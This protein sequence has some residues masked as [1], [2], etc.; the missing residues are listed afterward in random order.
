MHIFN[1][2]KMKKLVTLFICLSIAMVS[3][4]DKDTKKADDL[5]HGMAY[6]DAADAYLKLLKKGK[7]SRYVFEQLGNSYY[8]LNDLKKAETY[9]KRVAKGRR[10]NP[11]TYY[12]YAQVL[13][14]NGKF[15]DYG[16]NM[17]NFAEAKP[18]DSRAKAYLAT[19]NRVPEINDA[20]PG[21]EAKNLKELN[22]DYSEFG[23]TFV[24]KDF[25]FT[26]SRNT[27]RKKYHWDDQ[28]FLDIYKAQM[29]GSTLKNAVLLEGDVNT[30]YHE[31]NVAVSGD[32]K[33]IYFDRND[34]FNGNYEKSEDG[35]NQI[36]LFYSELVDGGWKGVYSVPFNSSEYSVGHPALSADGSTLYFVSD[37]P[38]GSGA[39]DIY[40][41]AVNAD[42]SFGKPMNMGA[43]INTEGKELFPSTDAQG[44]LYFSSNG[45]MGLGGLDVFKAV[46]QSNGFA[47]P[48]NLG[49]G[50]N[51]AADDF[52]FVYDPATKLGYVSSNR[53]GGK[54]M[55]DIYQITPIVPPCDVL[56]DVTV[57]NAYTDEPLFGALLSLYDG[58][59]TRLSTKTTSE[60]GQGQLIGACDTEL[61]VQASLIGFEPEAIV[62]EA[63]PNGTLIRTISLKPVEAIIVDDKIELETILFDYN[64]SD[65]K[66]QAAFEL[67]RLI[68]IMKKYPKIIVS[69]ASHSDSQGEAD[70]NRDLSERRAQA[71]VQYVID[72]GID[73]GRISGKGFG[74]DQPIV[75]CGENCSEEDHMKNRRSEF[76]IVKE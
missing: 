9:F 62:I 36:N 37:M 76:I 66:P 53:S 17:Q 31:G 6:G 63:H 43:G 48:E 24:G 16:A 39:S 38:G 5:Y 75:D 67:D 54:G 56:M 35:I 72:Q 42:G 25:Y 51:S 58:S 1:L 18:D 2:I 49:K 14:A 50:V 23:G 33:R 34:Y 4:Q 46:A 73:A 74:E 29:V 40:S 30:K 21:F 68:E 47:N 8:Q 59:D 44:N 55:D 71:T 65:I 20:F 70:Y 22:T 12:S 11:E 28:P 45:H 32:G 64:K 26:S 7:G 61:T 3:A 41:V 19:P 27:T 60:S 57:V 13:K 52:A 15:S 69:V 10:V